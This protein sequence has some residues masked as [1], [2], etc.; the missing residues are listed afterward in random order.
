MIGMKNLEELLKAEN[1]NDSIIEIDDF[2]SELCQWGEDLDK[3]TDPQKNFYFNQC[4]E[5]EVNNGG[6]S[7][8][9][10]NSSGGYAHQTV[11]TLKLIGATNFAKILQKAIDKFPNKVVPQ[12]WEKRK[13]IV[14]KLEE[15]NDDETWEKLDDKFYEYPDDLNRLNINYITKNKNFF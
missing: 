7:L 15:K 2:V 3:L 14:E 6:F 9:F 1:L 8:Y 10:T 4:L 13:E 12:D 11:E 5:R